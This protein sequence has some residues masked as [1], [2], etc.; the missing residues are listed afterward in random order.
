[1]AESTPPSRAPL[2]EEDRSEPEPSRPSARRP[3]RLIDA[4]MRLQSPSHPPSEPRPIPG[5]PGADAGPDRPARVQLIAALLLLLVLV[6]V[7]LYLW[8][9]PR[10]ATRDESKSVASAVVSAAVAP[11]PS[12][13]PAPRS[14]NGV[15]LAD[16]KV[17]GCHDPGS[18]RTPP[19]QCDHLPDF[20]AAFAK[21]ILDSGACVP[22]GT[23]A[24][25]IAF[26][27]DASYGRRRNPI[28]LRHRRDDTT[29]SGKVT[30]A[31]V[32]DVRKALSASSM[33]RTHTHS[34]YEIEI[35]ATYA[36]KP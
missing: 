16:A 19:D 7:P 3:L 34:R 25:Q 35:D 12:A 5:R 22:A 6:V 1:M 21:A 36:A 27:V 9:R 18:K 31:C 14:R 13:E 2:E 4:P 20:E 15:T 30:G 29:L 11:P 33:D 24:G 26:L 8:R 10:A 23:P 28:R 17:L 32:S